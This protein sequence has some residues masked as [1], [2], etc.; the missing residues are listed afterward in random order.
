MAFESGADVIDVDKP[1]FQNNGKWGI[2]SRITFESDF[3]LHI[4]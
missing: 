1:M 2:E 3:V 4:D